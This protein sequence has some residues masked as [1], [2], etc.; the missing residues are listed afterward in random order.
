METIIKSVEAHSPLRGLVHPGDTLLAVNGR[1]VLDVLDYKF[2][3]YEPRVL[4]QLR[5]AAGKNRL[6]L[7]RKAAG[8]DLGLEFGSYLMDRP[9]SCANGC[10]FCFIDQNPPGMRKS[11]YFKDDD[12]RLSFL[13]GCYITLTNLSPREVQRIIDL[14]V[15]PINVSVHTTDPGLRCRM[16]RS[17]RGGEALELMRRFARA[18]IRM[19]CQIVCCPGINDG[20]ALLSTL[21]DL[22]A[23]YPA[24]QS[25]AVVPVGLTAHREGLYPLSPFTP[26]GAAET[27]AAVERFGEDCR[28]ELGTRL[29]YCSDEL[30]LRAGLEVPPED[31]YEDYPQLENGVGMLRSLE[32]EF[33]RALAG[34]GEAD[35]VP[36]SIATGTAAA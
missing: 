14:R 33:Q 17:P 36:F 11:I 22:R 13:M 4:L 32:A 23:L 7:V 25:V 9:R 34:A 20:A 31:F 29:A 16:L 30:Y 12:A 15:S 10:I 35:G 26:E 28:R 24:V 18:G 19:N 8:A 2:Y 21:R 1:R 3:A 6:V 27:V 5:S